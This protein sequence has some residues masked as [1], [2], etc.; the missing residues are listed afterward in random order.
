MP[1]ATIAS[2]TGPIDLYYE[3]TGQGFPLIWCHEFGG[4]YRSWEPQVRYFSRRHRV[5]TWN[6][7][8]YPPSDVPKEPDAYSVEILV[9]DLR[10]LMR[11]LGIARAHVG[12]LSLGGGITVNFGIRYPE[13][14]ESLIIC[15]AGSGTV[16]REEFVLNAERQARLYETRGV[17]AKVE[18]FANT[19]TRRG[20][21][22]KD[23]RGWAEFLRN[24]HDHSGLGSALM[25][26][27]VMMKRKT[28]Y[29][30]EA[31]LKTIP[32]PSLI[33]VGDQDEPCLEPGLFMKR[34]I[35][36]AGFLVLPM[37]GHTSNIEEPAL[38]NQHV[39]EFL[40]AVESGRWGTWKRGPR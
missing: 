1:T 31:G 39:A 30:L 7:R 37:T 11:H 27:G 2:A 17:E 13:L 25:V 29:E 28:I 10:G 6:Y 5:I 22:E 33:V 12:G 16:G 21:A 34:H 26:R 3:E 23:P 32:V 40:T 15:A 4:D 9:D 18:N 36:H 38:F 14:S 20:F 8:G 35:P 19:P 24:V